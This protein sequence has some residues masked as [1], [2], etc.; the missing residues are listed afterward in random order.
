MA[1]VDRCPICA[2]PSV[3]FAFATA[4]RELGHVPG[5]FSM[6]RCGPCRS[7]FLWPMPVDT[8]SFYPA[9]YAAHTL[10]ELPSIGPL[11]RFLHELAGESGL[12]LAVGELCGT[13]NRLVD[14]LAHY[15]ARPPPERVLDVG[16]GT[17]EFSLRVLDG[18]RLPRKALLGIDLYDSVEEVGRRRGLRFTR[19]ALPHLEQSEFDLIV[20]SH[21]LEHVPD[22]RSYLRE[23][24]SRLA[25]GGALLL[26]VPSAT[27]LFG[28]LLPKIWAGH[29]VP[30]H[31]YCFSAR[32][33]DA[34]IEPLFTVARRS[35]GDVYGFMF[36]KYLPSVGGILERALRGAGPFLRASLS[37][38]GLGDNLSF[39][40]VRRD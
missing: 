37:P 24:H 38:L 20:M 28:R 18:L 14:L 40:L 5:E 21:V 26:S 7:Y 32:A 1:E 27:S 36:S 15:D 17:G 35:T 31:L 29:S 3:R 33:I 10:R 6:W 30:R 19:C 16:C 8:S 13:D 22:P 4:D 11:G 23:A 9:A 39:V 2:S 12:G 25:P 34:L